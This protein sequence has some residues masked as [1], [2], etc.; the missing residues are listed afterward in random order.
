[1][2]IKIQIDFLIRNSFC[3]NAE[4]IQ[5]PLLVYHSDEYLVEN[6]HKLYSQELPEARQKMKHG[7]RMVLSLS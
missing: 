4:M 7:K 5:G 2:N 1:M 6:R 3:T